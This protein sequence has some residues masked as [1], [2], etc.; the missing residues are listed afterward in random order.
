MKRNTFITEL[1]LSSILIVLAIFLLNPFK[2]FMPDMAAM[3]IALTLI[4]V[5]ALFAGFVWRE[6]ARDERELLHRMIAGRFAFLAGVLSLIIGIVIESVAHQI[7]H[8]LVIAL[9]A[10]ILAKLT[11]L[12]YSQHKH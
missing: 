2:L 3:T 9:C 5:F 10:M 1:V 7:D 11:G 12:I 4:V 8:W 6:H